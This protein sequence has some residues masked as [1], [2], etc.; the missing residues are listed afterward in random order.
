MTD[1]AVNLTASDVLSLGSNFVPQSSTIAND[2]VYAE[3]VAANGDFVKW[4][5]TFDGVATVTVPYKWNADTGLGTALPEIGS[6]SNAYHIDSITIETAHNDYPTI[7]FEAHQHDTNP[8]ADDRVSYALPAAMI[9]I[10]T[11]AL[12]AYDWASLAAAEVCAQSSTLTLSLNHIDDNCDGGNHWVGDNVQGIIEITINYIGDIDSPPAAVA[13][14]KLVHWE[15]NDSNQAFD[16]S[17]ATYRGFL[18]RS[19]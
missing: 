17:S 7:T 9:A 15:H 18:T 4:S 12:G 5:D 19:A 1:Q 2:K 13:D 3:M 11:G 16:T 6:V 10:A 14:M 8:H